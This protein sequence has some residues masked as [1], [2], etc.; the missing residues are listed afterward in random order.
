MDEREIRLRIAAFLRDTLAKNLVTAA[1]LGACLVGCKKEPALTPIYGAPITMERH[2][3]KLRSI[4]Q[5]DRWCPPL[6]AEAAIQP[7]GGPT[8]KEPKAPSPSRQ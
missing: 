5:T 3:Q 8:S 4:G 1:S 6:D 2:C 7:D